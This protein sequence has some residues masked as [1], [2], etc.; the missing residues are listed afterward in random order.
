MDD[1]KTVSEESN[2]EEALKAS[3]EAV[4][5]LASIGEFTVSHSVG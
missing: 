4:A 1:G 5:F 2:Y 3:D